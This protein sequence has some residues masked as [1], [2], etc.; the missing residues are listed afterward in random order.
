MRLDE[1]DA[2]NNNNFLLDY[3]LQLVHHWLNDFPLI[4]SA[5]TL[6]LQSVV[7]STIVF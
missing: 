3:G 5:Q 2:Y 6:D 4:F 1:N 7:V